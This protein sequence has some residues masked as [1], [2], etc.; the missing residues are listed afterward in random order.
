MTEN[1]TVRWFQLKDKKLYLCSNVIA[2]LFQLFSKKLWKYQF[3]SN[4]LARVC[5][6]MSLPMGKTWQKLC[7]F[8]SGYYFSRAYR[9]TLEFSRAGPRHISNQ[10]FLKFG[11]LFSV[12][13]WLTNLYFRFQVLYVNMWFQRTLVCGKRSQN[14][15]TFVLADCHYCDVQVY[16]WGLSCEQLT[17]EAMKTLGSER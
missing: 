7:L 4:S 13:K 9:N 12:N 15:Q 5:G 6:L 17:Y 2:S 14:C 16:L 8:F 11:K 1:L 3:I 10:L